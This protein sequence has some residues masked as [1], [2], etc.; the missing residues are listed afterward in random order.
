MTMEMLLT[1]GDISDRETCLNL[2]VCVYNAQGTMGHSEV[3]L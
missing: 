3:L 2:L 1:T